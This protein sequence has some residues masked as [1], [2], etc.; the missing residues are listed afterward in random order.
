MCVLCFGLLG[1]CNTVSR[2][3]ILDP[4]AE[5]VHY[6]VSVLLASSDVMSK[7]ALVLECVLHDEIKASTDDRM[8]PVVAVYHK[9]E[10]LGN[11]D[12]IC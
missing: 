12:V 2:V 5:T 3:V 9:V 4:R 6:V 11:G 1:S 8:L 10:G 7:A